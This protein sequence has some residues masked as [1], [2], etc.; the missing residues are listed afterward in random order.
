MNQDWRRQG[1]NI[2][3]IMMTKWEYIMY[4]INSMMMLY[5]MYS[6]FGADERQ[7]ATPPAPVSKTGYLL[8]RAKQ[9]LPFARVQCSPL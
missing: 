6:H 1:D 8:R 3:I 4:N 2:I 5:M 9:P 7:G